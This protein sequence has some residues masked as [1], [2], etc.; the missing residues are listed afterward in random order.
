M[1]DEIAYW[2]LLIIANMYFVGGYIIAG[3][4]WLIAAI[5]VFMRSKP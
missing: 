3:A 2:A 4:L 5:Y 1:K